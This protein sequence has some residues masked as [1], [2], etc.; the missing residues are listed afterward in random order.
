MSTP[1]NSEDKA[2]STDEEVLELARERFDLAAEAW[3]DIHSDALEDIEF[4]AGKQWDEKLKASREAEGK[5]CLTISHIH[6]SE[7]QI[8]NDQRQNR[9]SIKIHPVDDKADPETAEILQGLV[10]HIENNSNA[11]VAYDTASLAQARGGFGFLRVIT[12]YCDPMTFDQEILIKRIR[13]Q[14]AALIDPNH[15]EPDGSDANWGFVFEDIPKDIYK[16]QYPNSKMASIEDWAT[17]GNESPG[18]SSGKNCRIADYY[19]KDFKELEIFLLPGGQVYTS[20]TLPKNTPQ[21]SIINKRKTL[22]PQLK[23]YKINGIEILEKTDWAGKYVPLIPVYGDEVVIRDKVKYEGIVRHA[24]DSQRMLNY[25]KSIATETIGLAPKA[26]WIGYTGQFKSPNWKNANRVSYAYLEVEPV[27]VNGTPASLPQ[28]NVFEPPV[29]AINQQTL[30]SADDIK[31]TLGV[32]NPTLGAESNEKSGIAIQRRNQQAQTGNFHLTDNLTRAIKH[33]G[34]I[35]VDLIPHIYDG[36]RAIR[37]IGEEGDHEVVRINEMFERKGQKVEYKLDTGKYDVTVQTGPSY[38]TKRQEAVA[39]MIEVA[40]GYP[41]L[42]Q[43]AGDLMVKNMDWP[44]ANELA[45]RLKK[46]LPPGLAESDDDKA[47]IPPEV[48]AQMQQMG[49]QL[50]LLGAENQQLKAEQQMKSAELQSKERI[51]MAEVQAKIEIEAAKLGSKEAI[52]ELQEQNARIEAHL[53]RLHMA[54]VS[55]LEREHALEDA[56]AQRQFE[57]EQNLTGEESPG[58]STGAPTPGDQGEYI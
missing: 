56:E 44:G 46:T 13:N 39:S 55:D 20:E 52:I 27:T 17:I 57:M 48:Q 2:P 58:M 9:P 16:Q 54:D 50:E 6:Q 53:S 23:H 15:Q 12:D 19:F 40:K 34:R 30:F 8:T 42:M 47:P 7:R 26:P 22:I 5:P 14:F 41:P 18:W 3:K 25:W 31:A 4:R 37:I 21:E 33:V 32:H 45:E 10:R 29:Q 38:M 49:Q 11:D 35:I 1:D 28:R 51:A 43:N 36:A 24:K